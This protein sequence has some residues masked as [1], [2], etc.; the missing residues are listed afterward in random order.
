MDK[1]VKVAFNDQN[2]LVRLEAAR[3]VLDIGKWDTIPVLI[4]GLEDEQISTRQL[5]AWALEAK[6]GETLGFVSDAPETERLVSVG[7]WQEWWQL[8]LAD[9]TFKDNLAAR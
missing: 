8:R 1:L 7:K 6:T 4:I 9:P 3:A 2:K 5:C